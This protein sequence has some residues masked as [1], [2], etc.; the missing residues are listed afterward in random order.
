MKSCLLPPPSEIFEIASLLSQ[1]P[2]AIQMGNYEMAKQILRESNSPEIRRWTEALW[3]KGGIYYQLQKN[4]GT[5]KTIP[6]DQRDILRMPDKKLAS[7]LI[8]RDGHYCRFCGTPVIRKE[9][10]DQLKSQFPDELP[11]GK[12]NLSQHAAFQA[13]WLQYDH[14]LPHAR[15]GRT[16]LE[17]MIITCAPCNYGRMNF[18]LEEIELELLKKQTPTNQNWT[19]LEE[20]IP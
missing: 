15:G 2:H 17:N 6:L 10:R 14:I 19:G 9:I 5:P 3:G 7:E 11:W 20:L 12:I 1:I 8:K 16:T 13:M 18:L 4:L